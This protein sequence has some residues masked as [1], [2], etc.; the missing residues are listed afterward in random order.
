MSWK[1]C[2][3]LV[4][5]AVLGDPLADVLQTDF[6]RH[7]AL[8]VLGSVLSFRAGVPGLIAKHARS[9]IPLALGCTVRV[10]GWVSATGVS[11]T[12]AIRDFLSGA[13]RYTAEAAKLAALVTS[14][15]WLAL[16]RFAHAFVTDAGT[17]REL[18]VVDY[19]H[20]VAWVIWDSAL[21]RKSLVSNRTSGPTTQASSGLFP[22]S[23]LPL[24]RIHISGPLPLDPVLPTSLVLHIS[25]DSDL[26]SAYA[27]A[28]NPVSSLSIIEI[29]NQMPVQ[30][31]VLVGGSVHSVVLKADL[32]YSGNTKQQLV[33][34]SLDVSALCTSSVDGRD[35]ITTADSDTTLC[36]LFLDCYEQLHASGNIVDELGVSADESRRSTRPLD[37]LHTL[38]Y[39]KSRVASQ[40]E[41]QRQHSLAIPTS[42]PL[43]RPPKCL[44]PADRPWLRE[45]AATAP[46]LFLQTRLATTPSPS[47]QAS[48]PC[49][50]ENSREVTTAP[51]SS[52]QATNTVTDKPRKKRRG[53]K[54]LPMPIRRQRK[55]ELLERERLA[56]EAAA[57]K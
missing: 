24:N 26:L 3:V 43:D 21:C 8:A 45:R 46:F 18:L 32:V 41:G 51:S 16:W 36:D 38:M 28:Y 54:R 27:N 19:M 4:L 56:A 47:S 6:T 30:L 25:S 50:Q 49:I 39:V 35:E 12:T 57:S 52:E 15:C 29:V 10:I 40:R 33:L 31:T 2:A 37:K 44:Q 17:T 11:T 48:A 5:Y 14:D 7:V 34:P 9:W 42:E 13:I 20:K 22:S 1:A 55:R 53:G 23:T